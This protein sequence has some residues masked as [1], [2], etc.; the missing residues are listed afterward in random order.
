M[1]IYPKYSTSYKIYSLNDAVQAGNIISIKKYLSVPGMDVNRGDGQGGGRGTYGDESYTPLM[2]ASAGL[3]RNGKN[4]E[5]I[6]LLL[7]FGA[8]I[9]IQDEGGMTALMYAGSS[10]FPRIV[11]A[12]LENDAD[13]DYMDDSGETVLS[14]SLIYGY[15]EITKLLLEYGAFPNYEDNGGGTPLIHALDDGI[16]SVKLLLEHGADPLIG[17]IPVIPEAQAR[18]LTDIVRLLKS[19]VYAIR[20]QSKFRGKRTR[21]KARTQKAIQ[22]LSMA[23]SMKYPSTYSKNTRYVPGIAEM[24]S[25]YISQKQ[26]NPEVARRMG[27]EE[28]E[29]GENERIA[30]YLLDMDDDY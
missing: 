6:E 1:S 23:K 25:K 24:V 9:D 2:A 3:M 17:F 30:D 12:L 4:I 13:P 11:E 29:E 22:R 16:D 5:I 7:S 8:D 26:Y 20:V 14:Y 27:E 10:G 18:G 21:R 19:H 28:R 15:K